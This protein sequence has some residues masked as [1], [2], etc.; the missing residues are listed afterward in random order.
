MKHLLFFLSLFFSLFLHSQTLR[1]KPSS[2]TYYIFIYDTVQ[3]WQMN[4]EHFYRYDSVGRVVNEW[5]RL[6]NEDTSIHYSH[7][8]DKTGEEMS[9]IKYEKTNGIWSLSE[10]WRTS[11]ILYDSVFPLRFKLQEIES[12][13]MGAWQPQTRDEFEWYSNGLLKR[14]NNYFYR[15]SV[16]IPLLAVWSKLDSSGKK[17]TELVE[18]TW[19][20]GSSSSEETGRYINIAGPF[21]KYFGE[22]DSFVHQVS[23]NGTWVNDY[24]HSRYFVDSLGSYVIT[25]WKWNNNNWEFLERN[26]YFMIAKQLLGGHHQFF[27]NPGDNVFKSVYYKKH[28]YIFEKNKVREEI[29]YYASPSGNGRD[30]RYVYNNYLLGT[31][32]LNVANN[33]PIIYPNPTSGKFCITE[34]K[35]KREFKLMNIEG[36]CLQNGNIDTK[37]NIIDISSY[38]DGLYILELDHTFIKVCKKSD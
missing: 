15:D 36:K 6:F 25:D 35:S 23:Q 21:V 26:S 13:E 30:R 11:R 34:L 20:Y 1:D 12:F 24:K 16:Y 8:Y 18:S 37:N 14:K 27:T 19:A 3:D 5:V 28:E 31:A 38:K 9:S 29:E 7:T 33:K 2:L 22:L 4:E 10:G 17:L 32:E